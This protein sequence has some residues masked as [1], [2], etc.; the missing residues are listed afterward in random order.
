MKGFG[1][2]GKRAV[3]ACGLAL[4]LMAP[5]SALADS[6][7]IVVPPNSNAYGNKYS[8]WAAQWGQMM[9]SIPASENPITDDIGSKCVIGQRGPIWFL[10]GNFGG[11]TSRSC[12]IPEH[13]ALFFPVI[14]FTD[15]NVANQTAQDLR[16]EIA[17][18]V[19][20]V[21]TLSVAVDGRYVQRLWERFLVRSEAFDVTFPEGGF[22][23]PGTYSPAID[24][25]YYVMLKPL[26][27]GTH[28]VQIVGASPA[29]G[30]S[31]D[32]TYDLTIVPV[33]VE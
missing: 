8:E 11:T 6:D 14:N 7:S 15:I 28:T 31:L 32:V 16:A 18:C 27:V 21:T 22:L 13:K 9:F 3:L 1:N 26:P 20:G 2:C 10:A 17:P 30:L 23:D 5:F 33:S 25:G 4:G 19:Q 29:C 12:A 24:D